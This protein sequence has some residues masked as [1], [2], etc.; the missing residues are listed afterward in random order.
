MIKALILLAEGFEE[1]EAVTVID[2]LRRS[3]IHVTVA[4]LTSLRV[5]GSHGISIV[6]DTLFDEVEKLDFSHLI[7]PGGQPGTN[8]LKNDNRVLELVK[9]FQKEE[10][11]LAAI[12]AAPTVLLKAGVIDSVKI[13]SFPGEKENF[14]PLNYSEQSVVWDGKFITSRGVGTAIDFALNIVAQIKGTEEAEILAKR[15]VWKFE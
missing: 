8:N 12:C 9:R 4:G 11:I 7:L 10:R 6:A 15:I 3:D 1:T 14:N 2:L 13:T 5:T